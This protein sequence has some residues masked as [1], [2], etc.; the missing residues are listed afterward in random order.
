M[1]KNISKIN[2][3][4]GKTRAVRLFPSGPCIVETK[5]IGTNLAFNLPLENFSRTGLLLSTGPYQRVP[6]QV[7]TILELKV[8]PKGATFNQPFTFLAK[9]VRLRREQGKVLQYGLQLL[10]LEIKDT[11]QWHRTIDEMELQKGVN[12]LEE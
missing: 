2:A 4:D 6:F 7:N 12:Y 5:T 10:S 1:V 8:D 9:I 11:F 3:L